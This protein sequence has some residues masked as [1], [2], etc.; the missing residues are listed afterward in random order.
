MVARLLS[1][2]W[3]GSSETRIAAEIIQR[4]LVKG[5]TSIFFVPRISLIEQT[6]AAFQ[7]E[8]I[9]HIGVIYWRCRKV[10]CGPTVAP[11][12]FVPIQSLN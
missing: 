5:N 7:R 10:T 1:R 11:F 8:G 6:V 3:T 9:D 12:V 2:R 4:S